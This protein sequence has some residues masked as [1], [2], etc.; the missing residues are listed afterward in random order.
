MGKKPVVWPVRSTAWFGWE[1]PV[2]H[3]RGAPTPSTLPLV[4]HPT[5]CPCSRRYLM[6]SSAWKRSVGGNV[7]P[8]AWAVF[9]LMTSSN[10][11]LLHGQVGGLGAF[12]N[13][14]HI[15]G[16]ASVELPQVRPVVHEAPGIHIHA[17]GVHGG[18]PMLQRQGRDGGEVPLQEKGIRG[19]EECAGTGLLYGDKD[20][21]ELVGTVR[22]LDEERHPQGLS[23]V[24]CLS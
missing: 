17:V 14:V 8:S 5:S 21:F 7:I 4:D 9:R 12:Q 1:R 3:G 15:V 6:T 11:G 13:A 16:C 10:S 24:L 18:Q 23:R 20:A 19:D 22:F 2:S